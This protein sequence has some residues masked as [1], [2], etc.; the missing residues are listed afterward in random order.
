MKCSEA[1]NYSH[2]CKQI[3][4]IRKLFNRY[5]LNSMQWY[6]PVCTQTLIVRYKYV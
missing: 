1:S 3:H 2:S 5:K 6:K 4:F